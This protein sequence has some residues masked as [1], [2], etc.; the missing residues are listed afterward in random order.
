MS[1]ARLWPTGRISH[2]IMIGRLSFYAAREKNRGT[3][4]RPLTHDVRLW[5]V[6]ILFARSVR[7]RVTNHG[8]VTDVLNF[9]QRCTRG[10]QDL[11][12]PLIVFKLNLQFLTFISQFLIAM[13]FFQNSILKWYRPIIHGDESYTESSLIVVSSACKLQIFTQAWAKL[14]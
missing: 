5:F 2:Q 12:Q 13:F 6:P 9:S 14:G 7:R 3:E 4:D 1:L 8:L 11:S 10:E